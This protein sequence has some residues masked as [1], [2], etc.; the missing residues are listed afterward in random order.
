[1]LEYGNNLIK[2]VKSK[3]ETSQQ[4][5]ALSSP[6]Q[7]KCGAAAHHIFAVLNKVNQHLFKI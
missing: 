1:M 7:L 4:M 5:K 6:G 2:I 3:L